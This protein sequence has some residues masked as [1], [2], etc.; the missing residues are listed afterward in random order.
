M[1]GRSW[2][3]LH[4]CCWALV[5]VQRAT[6]GT[7]PAQQRAHAIDVAIADCEHTTRH[8][9]RDFVLLPEIDLRMGVALA[10]NGR[11]ANALGAFRSLAP[12]SPTT[13]RRTCAKP[14]FWSTASCRSSRRVP[15]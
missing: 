8:S 13:G 4:H 12:S 11:V 2:D 7:M 1:A 15:C 10:L 9:T 14:S 5:H 3:G 6:V